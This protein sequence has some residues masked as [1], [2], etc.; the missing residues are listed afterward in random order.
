MC[1]QTNKKIFLFSKTAHKSG[2]SHIMET[3]VSISSSVISLFLHDVS[4]I[5]YSPS[6]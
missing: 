1:N 2:L 3:K 4:P 6:K 5:P